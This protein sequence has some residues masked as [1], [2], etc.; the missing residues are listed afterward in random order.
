[1]KSF[2]KTTLT[3]I[4][5]VSAGICIFALCSRL[6]SRKYITVSE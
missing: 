5:G 1:M 6:L 2:L 4:T 3:V